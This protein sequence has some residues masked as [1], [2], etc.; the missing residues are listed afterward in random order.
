VA[1]PVSASPRSA[2][3]G[4]FLGLH[5]P[6]WGLLLLSFFSLGVFLLLFGYI[7]GL[8]L[9][10]RKRAP[11][12]KGPALAGTAQVQSMRHDS[13]SQ[14]IPPV[15]WIA[16]RVQLPGREPYDAQAKQQVPKEVY[17]V[18]RRGGGTVAVQVDSTN[19]LLVWI[20]FTQSVPSPQTT[21]QP[22]DG[23]Q[24]PPPSSSYDSLT[25]GIRRYVTVLW[26]LVGVSTIATLAILV[27][28]IIF[29]KPA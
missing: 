22:F 16:L 28:L 20:D 23:I 21:L 1:Y 27:A 7:P 12:F 9:G 14:S 3:Y 26:W 29:L 2:A 8:I 11:E 13:N 25:P 24:P 18:L 10:K 15:C 17:R 19:P 6:A 4:E 5:L